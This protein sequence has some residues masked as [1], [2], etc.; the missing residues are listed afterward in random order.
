M[1]EMQLRRSSSQSVS[2][3][4]KTSFHVFVRPSVAGCMLIAEIKVGKKTPYRGQESGGN[5][6]A[7]NLFGRFLPAASP[8]L[9]AA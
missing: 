7:L 6:M 3:G 5:S 9:D 4:A 2:L 8:I 1:K